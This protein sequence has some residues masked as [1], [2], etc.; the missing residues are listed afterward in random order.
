MGMIR[1]KVREESFL[2]SGQHRAVD[3][4]LP[5]QV[6]THLSFHL[7]DLAEAKNVLSDDTPGLVRVG[8]VTDNFRSDHKRGNEKAVARRSFCGR[9]ASLETLKEDQ[10]GDGYGL[11]QFG[12][13]ESIC[14]EIG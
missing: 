6:S 7:V 11:V 10:R 12:A 4:Q 3:V 13:V 5:V 8:I 2:E 9:K 14:D 1:T